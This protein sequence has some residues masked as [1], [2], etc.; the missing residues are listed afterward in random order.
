MNDVWLHVLLFVK[1]SEMCAVDDPLVGVDVSKWKVAELKAELT[2][3]HL[4][5]GGKKAALVERLAGDVASKAGG[6][7]T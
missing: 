6:G 3:R 2:R 1:L 7:T 5:V 4:I